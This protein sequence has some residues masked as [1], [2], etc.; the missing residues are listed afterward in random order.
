MLW[1]ILLLVL[2]VIIWLLYEWMEHSCIRY[3]TTVVE[4]HKF[5][6]NQELKL[7]LISD[8]HNN[9]KNVEKLSERILSFSPDM[10]I[11]AGDLVNKRTKIN[12]NAEHLLEVLAKPGIPIYYSLGNHELTYKESFPDEWEKLRK[13][14]PEN[15]LLLE[16]ES[17]LFPGNQD[18]CITGLSI[19]RQF[20]KKGRLYENPEE[21]PDINI[22]GNVWHIL[23]AH[24]P[25]YALFYQKY[26]ADFIVSGHLHGGLIRLP[27]IG[28][29]VSP[30]FSLPKYDSGLKHISKESALFVSRGLGSHTIPLRFFNRVEVNFLVVKDKK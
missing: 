26:H 22:P 12:S 8:L 3:E 27:V 18:I 5:Q 11:I 13:K 4:S 28:G 21:L 30:R 25:E 6:N 20:Y 2:L 17:V 23:I 24:N 14:F 15:V 9:K 10:L 7:C 1:C 19:P 16:N 29:L